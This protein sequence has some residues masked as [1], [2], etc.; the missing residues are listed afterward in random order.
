MKLRDISAGGNQFASEMYA[1]FANRSK[2]LLDE[3][4][5]LLSALYLDPRF[6]FEGTIFMTADLRTRAQVTN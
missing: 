4:D 5:A 1:K 3:N 2:M 6:N